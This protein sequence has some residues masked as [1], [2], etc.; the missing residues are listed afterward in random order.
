MNWLI[1]GGCGFIGTSL[2]SRI[3]YEDKNSK[4]VVIDNLKVG[5]K[6]DLAQVCNFDEVTTKDLSG[7]NPV[8]FIHGDIMDDKTSDI[9]CQG[10]DA[11]IHLAANTGVQPS[12]ENPL[13]DLQNNI[14]GTFNYLNA[15]R[16]SKVNIFITA[17]SGA[18]LGNAEPPLHEDMLTRPISPY[19]ASKLATEAYCSAFYNSYGLKTAVLRFS[20][21]YGPLS[22][23]K[24]SVVA[25]FIRSSLL[26]NIIQINGNGSQTR[27]F[28]YIDDLVDAI[29]K[30]AVSNI[31]QCDILQIASGRETSINQLSE[32]IIHALKRRPYANI[33]I[34]HRDSL[35]GDTKRN[36]AVIEKAS[37]LLNWKPMEP[38]NSG[39]EKTID[40]FINKEL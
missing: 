30:C 39:I 18:T 33:V 1:T 9:L 13:E 32:I 11:I 31:I 17:S 37:N 2:I 21:V 36:Y 35:I 22:H 5:Q 12:I 15:A 10:M 25:K 20:N 23:R 14:I 7:A 16:K 8:K 27:D 6:E 19:G 4:I 3:L 29:Y 34:E 28:I 26:K 24:N 38:L 40:F